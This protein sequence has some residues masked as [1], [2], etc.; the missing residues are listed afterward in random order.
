SSGI[1]HKLNLAYGLK[2]NSPTYARNF[3][4]FGNQTMNL[5]DDFGKDYYRSNWSNLRGYLGLVKR[6]EY[7][8]VLSVKAIFEGAQVEDTQNRYI[9]TYNSDASFFDWRYFAT[10]EVG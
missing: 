2:Y 6:S 9:T 10:A 7:G 8:G 1:F 4:G 5:E 3:F